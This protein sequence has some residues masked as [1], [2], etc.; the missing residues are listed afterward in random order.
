MKNHKSAV[1]GFYRSSKAWYAMAD[2]DIE[3]MFGMYYPDDG[4]GTTGEMSMRWHDLGKALPV[5]RLEVYCDA[6]DALQQFQD[7][8]AILAEHDSEDITEDEF[9]IILQRCGVQDLT[10]YTNDNPSVRQAWELELEK[11]EKRK[12]EIEAQIAKF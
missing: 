9:A 3:I 6:W 1:R 10:P 7:V 2:R 4:G 12:R 5:P 8:L 11:L